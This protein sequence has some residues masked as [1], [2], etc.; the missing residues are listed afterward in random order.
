VKV[1]FAEFR[2]DADTRQLFR[3]DEERHLTPKA[4]D[5]LRLLIENRPNAI[6]KTELQERLWPATFVTEANL[7]ILI[8]EIRKALDDSARRSRFI[9]TVHRFGY[10]FSAPATR[11]GSS[12]AG[13]SGDTICWL[14]SK[15][16]RFGL[17]Q[18]EHLV[19][20]APEADISLDH[21]SV[22]RRHA[23]I[24]VTKRGATVEDLGSKNGTRVGRG[25]IKVP[26]T[27]EDGDRVRFGSVALTFRNWLAG[28][29]TRSITPSMRA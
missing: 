22:S 16:Q 11:L 20:R 19:G 10:A 18:G 9:R 29:T 27:L 12:R 28:A 3:K 26:T 6:S 5:L 1:R 4:F 25:R 24:L 13:S 17:S 14:T 2:V 7:A 15:A 21:A 8:G 23:R